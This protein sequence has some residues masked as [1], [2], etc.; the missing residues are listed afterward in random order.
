MAAYMGPGA[1][2]GFALF[3]V[4]SHGQ[5]YV[6]A[7]PAAPPVSGELYRVGRQYLDLLDQMHGVEQ[8]MYARVEVDAS[9]EEGGKIRAWIY[10]GMRIVP[11]KV[12][13]G[14]WACQDLPYGKA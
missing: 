5:A 9:N 12:E 7:D 11:Q 1:I 10:E 13:S 14:D 4:Q 8:G 2:E 3:A 6:V